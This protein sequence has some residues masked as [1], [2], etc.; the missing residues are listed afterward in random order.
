MFLEIVFLI[1]G[2]IGLLLSFILMVYPVIPAAI[3]SY[4]ALCF[5]H[6][7]YFISVTES[8]F[9]FWGIA[10]LLLMTISR[11]SP[12]A[13]LK[14]CRPMN[15]YITVGAL[16]GMLLGMTLS[17]S[18]VVLGV[19]LGA[20]CGLL[21]FVNTYK[22]KLSKFSLSIFIHYF[23]AKGLPIIVAMAII[24]IVIEGFLLN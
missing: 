16:A 13:N 17:A 4:V 7:S 20:V 8:T 5:L 21:A 3:A 2:I 19:A 22:G 9:I 1:L 10:T 15:I 11:M 6:W 14:E 24:G 12:R 23:C 18:V